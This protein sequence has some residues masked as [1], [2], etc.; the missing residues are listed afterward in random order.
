MGIIGNY[1]PYGIKE[2][3]NQLVLF[4]GSGN[5]EELRREYRVIFGLG[6]K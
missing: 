6:S 4:L 5:F 3:L 2:F 1:I